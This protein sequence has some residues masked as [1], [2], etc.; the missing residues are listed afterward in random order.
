MEVEGKIKMNKEGGEVGDRSTEVVE[1]TN[2]GAGT[3]G[4][5]FLRVLFSP[6]IPTNTKLNISSK[7]PH[8]KYP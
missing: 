7:T 5:M 1:I 2:K 4:A 6:S 3:A 8:Y